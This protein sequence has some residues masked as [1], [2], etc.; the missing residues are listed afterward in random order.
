MA[1]ISTNPIESSSGDNGSFAPG[2]AEVREQLARLLDSPLFRTSRR[3]PALL[4]FIVERKLDGHV[5]CLKER[6]L[7]VEVFRRRSDY[8]T[9]QDPVVRV[10]AGEIRKRIAQY[11]QQS[12]HETDLRIELPLGSYVPVFHAPQAAPALEPVATQATAQPVAKSSRKSWWWLG[13][14]ALLPVAA[15]SWNRSSP[16]DQ[17]WQP[18]LRSGGP[19]SLC[20]ARSPMESGHLARGIDPAPRSSNIAWPDAVTLAKLSGLLQARGKSFAIRREDQA[21]F[22]DLRQ[23]PVVLIGAFNDSWTLRLMNDGRFRFR[24]EG[25]ICWIEDQQNLGDRRWSIDTGQTDATGLPVL[26]QDY[27]IVSRVANPK[28]G[29]TMVGVAGLWG[30]GTLAAG[31]LLTNGQLLRE[32]TA[33]APRGWEAKNIQVVVGTEVIDRSPGRPQILAVHAW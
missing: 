32:L 5:E 9:N 24:R 27:A 16:S 21:S 14:V 29:S 30:Y 10:S 7:G 12:G 1:T 15:L 2:N 4:R 17:F 26:T 28:T 11:Y 25:S 18:V 13:T 3:Y 23:G 6:T 33:R 20:V 31:E 8:D 19:V 22:S